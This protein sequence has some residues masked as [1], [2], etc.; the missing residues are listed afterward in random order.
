MP[1]TITIRAL[2]YRKSLKDNV[3]VKRME[4]H[5]EHEQ[6]EHN[7]EHA[8]HKEHEGSIHKKKTG[9]S[10]SF[11]TKVIVLLAVA[12]VLFSL[13]NILQ[14]SSFNSLFDQ[15]LSEAK[16]EA[17]PA[18]IQLITIKNSNCEDC[19]DILPIIENIK[20][21]NVD[22]TEEEELD[23]SLGDAK[24]LLNKY[25][26]EK[27][28]TVLVFGE[29]E[30]AKLNNLESREDALVFTSLEPP[31]TDMK[32][33]KIIGQVSSIII[34]D[35]S[36][37]KCSDLNLILDQLKKI[38]VK[39][40]SEK[41]YQKDSKEGKALIE[42]YSL[43]ISP[44]LILSKDFEEYGEELTGTW[45]QIGSIEQDGSYV[46]R[47]IS[48]P[49]LNL[50]SNKIVGL[51]SLTILKDKSCT[52][53]YDPEKFHKPIIQ[54]MGVVL[55]K[56]ETL[57]ISDSKGKELIDKYKIVAVP[58]IILKGD[59]ETY[60]VLVN[61]WKPVGTKETDGTYVFRKVDVAGQKYKD[62]ATNKIIDPKA[63]TVASDSVA[64]SGNI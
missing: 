23:I 26:I 50:S 33:N 6:K 51:V 4:E 19:F 60:P 35:S 34:E 7:K 24:E 42:K 55:E 40:T 18:K 61:A 41:T 21:S 12:I 37:D 2:V 38:G 25:N 10:K 56:E 53:C 9:L 54:R 3:E 14:I 44:T 27:V 15:K 1:E 49:Y 20:S 62:L 47:L 32:S 59:I 5:K 36:C 11:Y 45:K 48:P 8:E 64:T 58:T 43:K 31:Y 30:K 39:I 28:P 46:T 29:I 52:D 17:R 57:D 16:E 63:T 22:I 13:Y